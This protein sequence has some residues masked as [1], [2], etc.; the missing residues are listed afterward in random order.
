MCGGWPSPVHG[1]VRAGRRRPAGRRA[2]HTH[3]AHTEVLAARGPR[4][5]VDPDVLHMDDAGVSTSAGR[6]AALDLCL[7][8]VRL[9]HGSAVADA[10]ARPLVVPPHRAGG[11]AQFV[12]TPVPARDDHPLTA[13][14]PRVVGRLDRPLTVEDLAHRARSRSRTLGRHFNHTLGVPPDTY[15]RTSARDRDGDRD[16]D[17]APRPGRRTGP[18]TT[19]N[20]CPTPSGRPP[21]SRG[22]AHSTDPGDSRSENRRSRA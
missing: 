1:R 5:Q 8:L 17:R 21:P 19:V 2:R 6:A 3:R 14:L 9:D 18:A 16:R 15:R 13:L 10:V 20:P 12:A 22:A 11:R 4:V 7:H